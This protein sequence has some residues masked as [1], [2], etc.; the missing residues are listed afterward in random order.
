MKI[1]QPERGER[2]KKGEKKKKDGPNGLISCG[3]TLAP[4]GVRREISSRARDFATL[5]CT[6]VAHRQF[7]LHL[8]SHPSI[9]L[10]HSCR[11]LHITIYS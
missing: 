8:I 11:F 9:H 5:T 6:S 7:H 10:V 4:D 1:D 3:V 2:E